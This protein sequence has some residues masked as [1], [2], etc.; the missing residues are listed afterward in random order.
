MKIVFILFHMH[1]LWFS[2]LPECVEMF[3]WIHIAIVTE[4]IRSGDMQADVVCPH[5]ALS[6]A[7]TS[8]PPQ[9][10]TQTAPSALVINMI[11][12]V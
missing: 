8:S 1:Y 6:S 4:S 10:Q 11:M 7:S 12:P 5:T 9:S 3:T 2:Y